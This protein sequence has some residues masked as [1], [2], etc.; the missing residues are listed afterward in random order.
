MK[1]TLLL[2][3]LL[4][5]CNTCPAISLQGQKTISFLHF[6]YWKILFVFLQSKI[7]DKICAFIPDYLKGTHYAYME[8]PVPLLDIWHQDMLLFIGDY[9]R[10]SGSSISAMI[11]DE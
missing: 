8:P 9:P 4:G 5:E 10:A 11:A 6:L 7:K 1:V 3:K 2:W